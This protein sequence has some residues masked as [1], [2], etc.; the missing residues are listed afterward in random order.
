[1]ALPKR[2]NQNQSAIC[3][4]RTRSSPH[5]IYQNARSVAKPC[6]LTMPAPVAVSIRA[7][8]LLKPKKTN[9]LFQ[10]QKFQ[11]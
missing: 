8:K 3:G 6:Y 5:R 1:M 11:F 2:R 7:A 10:R 4:G 9:L